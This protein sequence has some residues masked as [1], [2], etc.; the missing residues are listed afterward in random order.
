MNLK[1]SS[2][3]L[4]KFLTEKHLAR[5]ATVKP[6]GSPH[7]TP[8]WYFWK[9]PHPLIAIVSTSMKVQNIQQNPW[10]AITIDTDG[11]RA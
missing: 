11:A 3:E 5:I 6:D 1:M 7:V 9:A 4:I 2:Q 10:V 8:V